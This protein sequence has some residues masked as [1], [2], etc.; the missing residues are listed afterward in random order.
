MDCPLEDQAQALLDLRD[1]QR[2][3]EQ[4]ME[5]APARENSELPDK[6]RKNRESVFKI[7]SNCLGLF[8]FKVGYYHCYFGS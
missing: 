2:Q 6:Q 1:R 4:V 8:W 5:D 3:E 7:I